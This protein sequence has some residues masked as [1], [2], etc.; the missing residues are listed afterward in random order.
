MP[1]CV[2]LDDYQNV[3]L[4]SADWNGLRQRIAIR[5]SND[6]VAG[7]ALIALLADAEIVVMMRERTP[8]PAEL[9][10]AL[11]KLK[12]LVTTGMRNAS[13]DFAAAARH[14][15][16]VCGTASAPGTTAELT[17]GLIHALMRAIPA[18]NANFHA[19]GPWQT[20]VG[21]DLRG[22]T[23]GVIGLG[24]LGQRVARVG[25]AFDMRV[26]GWS[27]SLTEETAKSLGADRAATLHDL[28]KQ[29]DIVSIHV[30]LNA[31]TRGL[32]GA[33]EF[34]VMKPTALLINTSRGPIVNEAALIEALTAG[35]IAGA[36][37]DVFDVE[38]LPGDHPLR[39][40]PNLIATPHLGY[41]T[42]ANYRAYFTGVV[43]DIAR[44]LDNDPVRVITG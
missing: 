20:S 44:W 27:R 25:V 26:L 16:T 3:A 8:F 9:F 35:R 36:G 1:T 6:T 14:G 19:G 24:N 22:A 2:I 23:L 43:E 17:W 32:I 18:E 40:L 34:A 29:S 37:L 10:A 7:D 38:P 11:P 5:V 30:P 31:G 42:Q 33:A 15:V 21:R 12:L 39:G 41:V 28:L 13:I 4:A